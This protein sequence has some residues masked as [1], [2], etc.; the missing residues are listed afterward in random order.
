[1]APSGDVGAPVTYAEAVLL[2]QH[3]EAELVPDE[4]RPGLGVT[5]RLTRTTR[6]HQAR[7]PTCTDGASGTPTAAGAREERPGAPPDG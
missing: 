5:M 4:H 6:P 1:M 7:R 3:V 2:L